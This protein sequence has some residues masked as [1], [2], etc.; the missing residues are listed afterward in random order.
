MSVKALQDYIFTAK[1]AC[2]KEDKKRRETWNEAVDRDEDMMMKKYADKPEVHEDIKWA[3]S[4]MRKKRVSGSQRALQFG[5]DPIFKHNVKMYNCAYAPID[6][7]SFFQKCMYCLLCGT[8]V[9]FSVQKHHI[10]MLP[11]VRKPTKG[12]REF[13]VPDS[14]EGWSDS[15]G[16][17]LSSYFENGPFPEYFGYEVDIKYHKVRR[18]GS[19]IGKTNGKSPGPEP[20]KKCHQFI[21]KILDNIVDSGRDFIKPIEAYDIV[22]HIAD[23]SISGGIRRSATI[24]LFSVDDEEMYNAKTGDWFYTN[25]Q[26]GRSNNSAVL[27]RNKTTWEQFD[28]VFQSTKQYGEPGFY[29][30]DD[31]NMGTNPC[32]NSSA[33]VLTKD[34][35]RTIGDIKIGD[36]IW[37]ETGW[38]KVLNKWSTGTKRVYC[39]KTAF[40]AFYGT[41]NHRLV[42]NGEKIEAKDC[43]SI[44]LLRGPELNNIIHNPQ[45]VMDGLVIG[46]GSIYKSRKMPCL[47]IGKN[48]KDYNNSEISYLIGEAKDIKIGW[49]EIITTITPDELPKTF[50]RTVPDRFLY[51]DPNKVCSF[52]RGLY[53]ANG[54]ICG[55]RVTLKATSFDI[56]E[57]VQ[58]MLSSVGIASYYTINKPTLVNFKN[59]EYLCKQSYDLNISRDINKFDR[60]IGFIQKYKSEKLKNLIAGKNKSTK[61]EQISKQI[62]S[63]E[64]LGEEEV[65]DITV[66][67]KTH[68]YWTGGCNVSNCCEIS[69]FPYIEWNGKIESDF[70]FCNLSTINGKK[71]KSREDLLQAVKA[72][73][74]IGTLQAG[75]TDF[76]YLGPI[77]EAIVQKEALLGVSITGIMDA[78]ELLLDENLQ[79][80][81]AE[82]AKKINEEIAKKI[83]INPAARITCLKPEGT[84][85][86]VF[87]TSSGI[88]PHHARRYFR[89]VQANT[90]EP[91]Y[92]FFKKKNKLACEKSVWS[93]NNTD[94]IIT[95]CVDVEK[96]AILKNDLPAVKMLEIVKNTQV[97]WVITGTNVDRC[98]HEKCR[99][100]V[101]NT[102]NVKE[103][104][105]DEV[106]KYIYN[107]MEFFTGVSVIPFSGDKDY[108]QAPFCEVYTPKEIVD[109]YGDAS[110]FASGLIV[111]GL[112]VFDNNLWVA[113]DTVLGIKTLTEV[114]SPKEIDENAVFS[115]YCKF[116]KEYAEYE[117]YLGQVDWIRRAKQFAERYF[118]NDVKKMTYC[119]KDVKNW[120]HWCD[121]KRE[122]K[123]M[124]Y[125]EMVEEEDNTKPTDLIAC[126]GGSCEI[127]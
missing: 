111:D 29:F 75:F 38:T 105:W 20:L 122:Y 125:T 53:S 113:C 86:C 126:S 35:I 21:K 117:K 76:P 27:V 5:G 68:T 101:S 88:H 97:N 41:E 84:T 60:L 70:H 52:L 56:I 9:G 116:E 31:E 108:Q 61:P 19:K 14:I 62:V 115:E 123:D 6:K 72:A 15:I 23:S 103:H 45:D 69:F 33:P 127:F 98:I 24:A 83:N 100:N 104:E 8:G 10:A 13:V 85:S 57:S 17:L 51:G 1:Y 11:K 74:I 112:K 58:F 120:K 44:D 102:I 119:L 94:D 34:G 22:M 46:D 54:S 109:N 55:G 36:E 90:T 89:R 78:A 32:H 92:Q 49:Y 30:A 93:N 71:I 95:F 82:L 91:V 110:I 4:Q 81:G 7:I 118:N 114:K 73:T 40:G 99:H 59:G 26:R 43:E 107:N 3:Y 18:K 64:E 47:I 87:G 42:S 2:Y 50:E 16:V 106:E 77:C 63:V 39:Y 25:P 124:D 79:R 37:S 80:E 67:N 96:G 12:V 28:R 121:L 48:D 65:F 66:D